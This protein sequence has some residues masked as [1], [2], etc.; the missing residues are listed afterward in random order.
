MFL[1]A[2]SVGALSGEEVGMVP[3]MMTAV[4]AL[5]VV[6]LIL[7]G[8]GHHRR[9]HLLRPRERRV[10]TRSAPTRLSSLAIVSGK[11]QAS[12]IP[13]LLLALAITPAMVILL[14]FAQTGGTSCPAS[15][16]CWR[17]SG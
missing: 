10:G 3:S 17:S 7:V 4:A 16:A 13:L 14:Y 6:L 15:S 12:I 1:V 8:P 5:I 2:A 11:F 9:R